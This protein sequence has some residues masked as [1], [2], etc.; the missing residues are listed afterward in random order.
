[1]TK[2]I[3]QEYRAKTQRELANTRH[4][5]ARPCLATPLPTAQKQQPT[6]FLSENEL[7]PVSHPIAVGKNF[8][9]KRNELGKYCRVLTRSQPNLCDSLYPQMTQKAEIH[10]R[11]SWRKLICESSLFDGLDCKPRIPHETAMTHNSICVRLR[12]LRIPTAWFRLRGNI[13]LNR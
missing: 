2:R 3:Q 6:Q 4:L 1:M 9:V 7:N 12:N 8:P 5:F 13:F 11:D 10:G